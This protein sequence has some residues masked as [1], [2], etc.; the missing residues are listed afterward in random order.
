MVQPFSSDSD[1]M[2]YSYDYFKSLIQSYYGLKDGLGLH[3]LS[4]CGAGVVATSS[5][6]S[7]PVSNYLVTQSFVSRQLYAHLRMS[8]SLG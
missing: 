4:S 3:V 2:Q 6:E 1:S 7:Y 8:S 5:V